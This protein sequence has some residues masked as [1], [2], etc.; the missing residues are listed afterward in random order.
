MLNRSDAFVL[1]KAYRGN[2]WQ[3]SAN[4]GPMGYEIVCECIDGEKRYAFS[5]AD[6]KALM[7]SG[8]IKRI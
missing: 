6:V 4:N 7:V 3:V 5:F 2:G 8:M 1:E